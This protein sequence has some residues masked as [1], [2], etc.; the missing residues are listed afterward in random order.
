[1][2]RKRR[3]DW[4]RGTAQ[5]LAGMLFLVAGDNLAARAAELPPATYYTVIVRP[6]DTVSTI[7]VRYGSSVTEIARLNRL[8]V[9]IRLYPG[10]VLRVPAV[11]METREAVLDEATNTSTPNYAAPPRPIRAWKLES[12]HVW[13]RRLPPPTAVAAVA[14]R[15]DN[16]WHRG[17]Q[18]RLAAVDGRVHFVWPVEGRVI[19]PFGASGNGERNDGINIAAPAGTPIRAAAAGT[20]SYAGHELKGYGNLVLIQHEDGYVTAYA[21]AE[22]LT[23][24]RG[25]HVDK[26]QVIGL[27]GA[28]GDVDR[29][30]LHFEIRKGITPVN[31]RLLLASND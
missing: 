31:P 11:S 1:M 30:Q 28:T 12:T 10:E 22:S 24:S 29:P 8:R 17:W 16:D 19:S 5:A 6:R 14:R 26:G 13:V 21:H 20:V 27:A 3:A 4:Q 15:Q 23:V 7:A 25:D 9:D 18:E 2:G